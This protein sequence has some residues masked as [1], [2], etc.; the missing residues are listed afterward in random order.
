MLYILGGKVSPRKVSSRRRALHGIFTSPQKTQ[1]ELPNL[2]NWFPTFARRSELSHTGPAVS[3]APKK[4]NDFSFFCNFSNTRRR[5][6][7]KRAR[8]RE[9]ADICWDNDG[10]IPS[11]TSFEWPPIRCSGFGMELL[12]SRPSSKIFVQE[13]CETFKNPLTQPM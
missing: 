4:K 2:Y 1:I 11:A 10:T 3:H 7:E 13:L 9:A 8:S 5:V 12:I 6:E